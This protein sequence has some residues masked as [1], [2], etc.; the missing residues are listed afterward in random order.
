MQRCRVFCTLVALRTGRLCLRWLA[1]PALLMVLGTSLVWG[2]APVPDGFQPYAL[3]HR[4]AGDL[5]PQLRNML[6]G[7]PEKTNVLIDNE[8]N[9]LL[10]QG[11]GEA[12]KVAAQ[13]VG[14]LD[15]PIAVAP[16]GNTTQNQVQGYRVPPAEL[17]PTVAR[18]QDEFGNIKDVRIGADDRTGQVIVVAPD[19]IQKKVLERLRNPAPQA[20][21][22][23]VPAG[24]AATAAAVPQQAPAESLTYQL[25][26]VSWRELED[27]LKSTWGPQLSVNTARG[28]EVATVD[29]TAAGGVRTV[30]EIDRRTDIVRLAGTTESRV[31][32]DVV[33]ALDG[34]RTNPNDQTR[35]V[36]VKKADPNQVRS[37]VQLIRAASTAGG[38]KTSA[39]K[40]LHRDSDG[41]RWGGELVSMLFQ[42]AAPAGA[43]PAPEAQAPA[44]PAPAPEAAET[45]AAG[46]EATQSAAADA[47]A[48]ADEEG[49]LIGPV[50]IEFL[51]GLDVI[52]VKG[53]KRD[54]NRVMR[55]I[56]DIE[57]ISDTTTPVVD[58]HI[59]K[60]VNDEALVTLINELYTEILSARQGQV[61][62]RALIEPNAVLLIGRKESVAVVKELIAKL[63][64][65][66]DP[67]SQFQ[68]FKLKYMAAVDAETAVRNF[69]VTRPGTGT[70]PR[71]GLG[72]Q[73]R[74]LADYRSNSL[75]VQASPRDLL[76]VK[77]M[78]EGI[79]VED[80]ETSAVIRVFRLKNALADD[81]REVIQGAITGQSATTGQG[82]QAGMQ[83][84][85]TTTGTQGGASQSRA[86]MPS[87][88]L[89]FM[90]VDQ[91]GGRLLR[92]GVLSNV[93]VTSDPNINALVV[94][95][96]T[97]SMDLIA[98][99]IEQL[100]QVPD[101]ESQIKVFT[102]VNG[103]ATNLTALLQ[104]LFGQQVTAGVGTTGGVFGNNFGQMGQTQ[105]QT[106]AGASESS[107]VPL[108]FAVDVRTNSIIA[109]GSEG[110]LN[111]VEALLLRL[112][113]GDIETRKLTVIR[114]KNAPAQDVANSI[115]QFLSSQRQLIQ[116]QL[117]FNQAIS[118]FEQIEREVIVVPELVTNSLIVSATPR[119]YDEILQVIQDLDFRPPMVMV[120]V[121][122][123]EVQL[124]ELFE[125]GVEWGLQDSL[126]FDRG[127]AGTASDPGFNFL[128]SG[129]PGLPNLNSAGRGT[130]AGRGISSLG[131]GATNSTLGA[132]GMV[133]SAASDSVNFLVRALQ[134][135]GR[136]QILSRPQVMTLNNQQAF[137]QVGQT[138]SRITG[139][140]VSQGIV[141]NNVTDVD[142]GLILRIQPLINDDGIIVMNVDA[143]RSKLGNEADGPVVAFGP[144]NEPIRSPPIDRT[145]AQTTVSA[146]S[147]QTVVFAGLITKDR[148]ENVTRV[149]Y[150]SDIPV[151]GKLFQF[152]RNAEQ[153][154]E[155]LIVMTP[156][157]IQ[158]DEDYEWVK[159][160]E[161]ERMSWCLADVVQAHGNVGLEGSNCMFCQP[162]APV[163][164]P[165]A[166]PLGT[167]IPPG[168]AEAGQQME[169]MQLMRSPTPLPPSTMYRQNLSPVPED[170]TG[171]NDPP[172]PDA[173]GS[174]APTPAD[175]AAAPETSMRLPPP[176]RAGTV[177]GPQAG[178]MPAQYTTGMPAA[179]PPAPSRRL[180]AMQ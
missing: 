122:I 80:H 141:Q 10:V 30:L 130:V 132:G 60:Y 73:V 136:L 69:F 152:E 119:Y 115:T 1:A 161:S 29:V 124:D 91:E 22:A 173:N 180:P 6:Q 117:L 160:V 75:I 48:A 99:L 128:G 31:W 138:Q 135:S 112:D 11:S 129:N 78:I 178:V 17:Q 43:P 166:D 83:G 164:Y 95:A 54:V 176:G 179:A 12:Q 158:S 94:R 72:T 102:V 84:G 9:R 100:D 162:Q 35:L 174:A 44:A 56:A 159:V 77:R 137:V 68:I 155:L 15:R 175:P 148:I 156:Y 142:T 25:K 20:P 104:Q 76:E 4:Q 146:R 2:Q 147:G 140:T 131:M 47:A 150:I 97:K 133:L 87:A 32:L 157:I 52:V 105:L 63:D 45:P 39:A 81:L 38:D 41:P 167:A 24:D 89:E 19:E 55:I 53:N 154:R 79:D 67:S 71:T 103:D 127:V 70:E 149:P 143:E 13:F 36:P 7:L 50:Q 116:Q 114:L 86:N 171:A 111:V 107:L 125:F 169:Q 108:R 40:T 27:E 8:T 74:I 123:A 23:G 92:S 172:Q 153:R 37:A 120:Q 110:D 145:T 85:G 46:S 51:E 59:L 26:N 96:P 33:K 16:G 106:G 101:A 163:L 113:E 121:L 14:A 177:A 165:V 151:L 139:S 34:P 98:A 109:S 62:I 64:Q 82:G 49:G 144:D 118:P 18:L 57:K 61:S 126:L 66:S 58:I 28:G 170:G 21:S 93:Q 168:T 88:V 42:E 134:D 3:K 65:P 5:A 90:M